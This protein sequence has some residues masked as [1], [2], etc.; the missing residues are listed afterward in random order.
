MGKWIKHGKLGIVYTPEDPTDLEN[1]M[2]RFL[3][4]TDHDIDEFKT[5]IERFV[6][7]ISWENVSRAHLECYR[8]R[9]V[10]F[11]Y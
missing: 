11:E 4:M 5:N 6:Q 10:V 9:T 1:A 3:S 8:G 2:V 7:K